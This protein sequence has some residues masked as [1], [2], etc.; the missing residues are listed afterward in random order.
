MF[1]VLLLFLTR[2]VSFGEPFGVGGKKRKVRRGSGEKRPHRCRPRQRALS[3][4]H[5][6][7]GELTLFL[8]SLFLSG[9]TRAFCSRSVLER[10]FR[11]LPRG[12]RGGAGERERHRCRKK[13][14]ECKGAKKSAGLGR[15]IFLRL[16]ARDLDFSFFFGFFPLSL[17]TLSSLH[18]KNKNQLERHRTRKEKSNECSARMDRYTEKER[19]WIEVQGEKQAAGSSCSPQPKKTRKEKKLPSLTSPPRRS[20][21]LRPSAPTPRSCPAAAAT[22][23]RRRNPR[24]PARPP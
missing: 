18:S 10:S 9:S 14:E 17:S 2:R 19:K 20:P 6:W 13:E 4:Y 1:G 7:G 16:S 5:R 21:S 23:R 15:K 8:I 12:R 24:T 3:R 22:P 11:Y